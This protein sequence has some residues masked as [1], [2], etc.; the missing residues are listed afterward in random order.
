MSMKKILFLLLP[1]AL[2][3]EHI[4]DTKLTNENKKAMNNPKIK[5]RWVCDKKLYE[6]QKIADAISFY[7]K[8]KYYKFT[9][10]E[11]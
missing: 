1:V 5:C 3:C 9:K 10:K 8:S 7:K 2:F 6:E 4:Y 11:F